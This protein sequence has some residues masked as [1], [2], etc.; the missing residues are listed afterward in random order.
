MNG[1]SRPP[2]RFELRARLGL[3]KRFELIYHPEEPWAVL[4]LTPVFPGCAAD[5]GER[6]IV[7]DL[8]ALIASVCRPGAHFVLNCECAYP[9]CAG[10]KEAVLVSHPDEESV[11]W[12]LDIAGLRPALNAAIDGGGYLRLVFE[13]ADYEADIRALLRD[14][15]NVARSPMPIE[16]MAVCV[17]DQS[18]AERYPQF[19]HIPVEELEPGFNRSD[20]IDEALEVDADA[21]WPREPLFAPGA[22]I[23]I[24]LFGNELWRVNGQVQRDWIGRYLTRWSALAAFSYWMDTVSR[25]FARKR[26]QALFVGRE[27]G[28]LELGSSKVLMDKEQL[29]PNEFIISA[30]HSADTAHGAGKAFA[31][32]FRR[33]LEEASAAPGVEVH[34]LYTPIAEV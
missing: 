15:Q 9:P 2:P 3:V 12:E 33:C 6:T 25:R 21:E 19:T 31:D 16:E 28:A 20:A 29:D 18:L 13:R 7:W 22:L 17:G 30:G 4:N 14:V 1:S 26:P 8:Q 10:L 24:G 27:A 5:L 11:C 32:A 23:E 34:Y